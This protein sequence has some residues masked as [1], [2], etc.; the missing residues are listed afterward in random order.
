MVFFR[1]VV[2]WGGLE[3]DLLFSFELDGFFWCCNK[4][5]NNLMKFLGEMFFLDWLVFGEKNGLNGKFFIFFVDVFV[6]KRNSKM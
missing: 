1:G 5:V 2:Y 4:L 3:K 6:I